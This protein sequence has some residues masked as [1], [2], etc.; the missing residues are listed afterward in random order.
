MV[1]VKLGMVM[2]IVVVV[3]EEKTCREVT[4]RSWY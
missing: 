4:K 2:I 3:L 1:V